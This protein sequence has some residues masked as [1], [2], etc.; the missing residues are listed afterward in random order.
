MRNAAPNGEDCARVAAKYHLPERYFFYPAQ[1]WRHKNHALIL[2]AL[3][4]IAEETSEAVPVVFCGSYSDYYRAGNFKEMIALV[5]EL[6]LGDRVH[7]LGI[8]PDEDMPA[9]YTMSAGLVM[10][11]FFGPTNIPPFEAWHYGRP[12]ICSNI[13]GIRE[14]IGDAGLLIDPRSPADLAQAMLKL[15]RDG[16]LGAK[17]AEAGRFRLASYSWATFVEGVAD[18]MAEACSLLRSGRTPRYPEMNPGRRGELNPAD[19]ESHP[20]SGMDS[21][22]KLFWRDGNLYRGIRPPMVQ[23]YNN[24]LKQRVIDELVKKRLLIDTW[25]TGW[26]TSEFPLVLQHRVLPVVSFASEW[27]ASQLQAAALNVLDL[28]LALR[29][30]S[31]TLWDV[32]PWNI[33]FDATHPYHVDLGSISALGGP[34]EWRAREQFEKLFLNPL[35]LFDNGLPRVARR[36][37]FDPMVGVPS[38]ELKGLIAARLPSFVSRTV[39]NDTTSEVTAL[40]HLIADFSFL[41]SKMQW[42][43]YQDDNFPEFLPS[44]R[45]TRKHHSVNEILRCTK[46]KTVFDMSANRGWYAQLAV[47]RG[48]RVIAA[49]TDDVA[50]NKLYADAKASNLDISPLVME[51]RFPEPPQGP[52]YKMLTSAADRFRSEMVLALALVHHLVFTCYMTFD[53]IVD[54]F[55]MFSSK[56]VAVEFISTDDTVVKEGLGWSEALFPWYTLDNFIRSL[57]RYFIVLKN[58]PSDWGELPNKGDRLGEMDRTILLCERKTTKNV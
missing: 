55:E 52:G 26:S 12:V 11:T 45:W 47:R 41:S 10:P 14:Q 40:R 7:Y 34:N 3:R 56:W 29:S 35:L 54:N 4:L 8:V 9:L 37:L 49:D 5:D 27:C 48:A 13:R 23:F 24:L 53:Q 36:L 38:T 2:R 50:I 16:S 22:G 28:E 51:F 25:D 33:V 46:P 58:L 21:T 19:I 32:S 30:K 18:V 17:L 15:W 31:L 39:E 1:F 57:E 42:A 43:G 20:L 6:R 44:A